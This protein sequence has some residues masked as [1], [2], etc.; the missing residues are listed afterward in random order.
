VLFLSVL[1]GR[2]RC[3]DRLGFVVLVFA[4]LATACTA[5]Q[6]P[7]VVV[8]EATPS[9]TSITTEVPSTVAP[10]TQPPST[11]P[12][13]TELPPTELPPSS[14]TAASATPTTTDAG[15]TG[16]SFSLG[17][18]ASSLLAATDLDDLEQLLAS[19]SGRQDFIDNVVE[20]LPGLSQD[21]A[22]CFLDNLDLGML[23]ALDGDLASLSSEQISSVL[24][25]M[26][27][28]EIPLDALSGS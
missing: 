24:A 4:L 17:A 26:L 28:C 15:Q 21:Q 27:T 2:G 8:V 7:D 20:A 19:D 13:S 5:G 6:V 3:R 18:T 11:Q 25:V 22:G 16:T 10:S 23:A 9:S 12:P 14:E 1:F